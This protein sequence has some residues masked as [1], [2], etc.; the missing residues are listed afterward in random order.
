MEEAREM[1]RR[2]TEIA[3]ERFGHDSREYLSALMMGG[4][5]MNSGCS[6]EIINEMN[7]VGDE[8]IDITSKIYSKDDPEY[9]NCMAI[10]AK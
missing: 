2:S 8:I 7:D 9:S 1:L 5:F 3:E 10:G 6:I 4:I